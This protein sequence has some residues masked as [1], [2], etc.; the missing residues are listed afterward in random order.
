MEIIIFPSL[1]FEKPLEIFLSDP[2]ALSFFF[3]L[4]HFPP[5]S[6]Y[7][8]FNALWFIINKWVYFRSDVIDA[9]DVLSDFGVAGI[10]SICIADRILDNIR[11][12]EFFKIFLFWFHLSLANRS[13]WFRWFLSLAFLMLLR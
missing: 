7:L 10:Q 13:I 5:K 11:L 6:L 8:I 2:F 9:F 1:F 12:I 3:K 4:G